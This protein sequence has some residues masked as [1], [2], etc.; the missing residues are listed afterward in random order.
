MVKSLFSLIMDCAGLEIVSN[1]IFLSR[2]EMGDSYIQFANDDIAEEALKKHRQR[3][4]DRC[5]ALGSKLP[6]C[7]SEVP[8]DEK[9]DVHL[10]NLSMSSRFLGA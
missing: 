7:F 10:C 8:P 1:G 2:K 4:R 5:E 3:M 6:S 9:R